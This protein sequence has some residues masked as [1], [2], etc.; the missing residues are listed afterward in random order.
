[1]EDRDTREPVGPEGLRASR[2]TGL[3]PPAAPELEGSRGALP[4]L[5]GRGPAG[6]QRVR[7]PHEGGGRHERVFVGPFFLGNFFLQGT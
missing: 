2:Y 6:G 5:P 7:R 1:M 3:S 4:G